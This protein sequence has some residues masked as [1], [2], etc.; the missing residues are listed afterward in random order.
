MGMP[1]LAKT[2]TREEVQA[3]LD[4][5]NR[6]E[7]VD[8]ELLVSPAPRWIHQTGVKRLLFLLDPYVLSNNLGT[9]QF[10][11]AD[12][13]LRAGQLVQPDLFVVPPI[14]GRRP[15]R[16]EECGVPILIVEVLSPATA[17]YDRIT[18]R[19]RYQRSGV[20]V[21]WVVDLDARLVEVWTPGD[22]KP[23]IVDGRL[24]WHP[25]GAAEALTIDVSAYISAV[26]AEYGS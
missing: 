6:Y 24:T 22:E 4:D 23:G 25:A 21:Y 19:R 18:K 20:P 7:L 16:W 12:L 14:D 9:V 11:P 5:G 13:D 15:T 3:L 8:G 17:Q 1:N 10:A 2:W 26:W